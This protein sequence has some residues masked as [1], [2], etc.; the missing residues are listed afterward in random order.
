MQDCISRKIDINGRIEN[1]VVKQYDNN[2]RYLHVAISDADLTDGTFELTG[3]STALFIQPE[4]SDDNAEV[5]FVGGE[6]A[7]ADEGIVTFLL[8]GG[9]TQTPG[10]YNAEIWI[11]GGDETHPIISTKPFTLVVEK[12]IRNDSAIEA[13]QSMSALDTKIVEVE[14][15]KRQMKEIFV[16]PEMFGAAGDGVTDDYQA[17]QD[18]IDYAYEH[19]ARVEFSRK[20]YIV[21]NTVKICSNGVYNGNNC[22]IRQTSDMPTMATYKYYSD[23][24]GGYHATLRDFFLE[25]NTNNAGNDGLILCGWYIRV[26]HVN[27]QNVGGHGI[28]VTSYLSNGGEFS[29]STHTMV[30]GMIINSKSRTSNPEKYPFYVHCNDIMITDWRLENCIFTANPCESFMKF[31]RIAG[32]FLTDVQCYG[33]ATYAGIVA[34]FAS[35]TQMSNIIVDGITNIGIRFGAQLGPVHITNVRMMVSR[36]IFDE[37][38]QPTIYQTSPT[39]YVI[40]QAGG[41]SIPRLLDAV[42]VSL[43]IPTNVTPYEICL[44]DGYRYI[45][46]VTNP[47]VIQNNAEIDYKLFKRKSDPDVF[48]VNGFTILSDNERQG[49]LSTYVRKQHAEGYQRNGDPPVDLTL[50]ITP[51]TK[52]KSGGLLLLTGEVNGNQKGNSVYSVGLFNRTSQPDAPHSMP[53]QLISEDTN[54]PF[55]NVGIEYNPTTNTY[56]VTATSPNVGNCWFAMDLIF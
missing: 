29:S 46:N 38:N 27:V 9:V 7:D 35:G 16:T 3:C 41:S 53:C 1:I 40:S 6:I 12:S 26:N 37:N 33:R 55:S 19:N 42:N 44:H 25:G 10:K 52:I 43:T 32:W 50:T 21:S 36:E 8:P 24:R 48:R 49:D 14:T 18:C 56:T 11:Y 51:S 13:S 47:S 17:I 15:L 30:E 34:N 28:V 31:D 5:S 45:F 54:Y 20:T 22:T 23:T 2:S 4:G 39:I